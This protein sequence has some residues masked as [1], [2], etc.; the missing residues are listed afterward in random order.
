MTA[1]LTM[2]WIT[3]TQAA[4]AVWSLAGL[5]HRGDPDQ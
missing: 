4:L 5:L 2:A 1:G 3:T